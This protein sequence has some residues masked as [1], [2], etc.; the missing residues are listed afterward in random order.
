MP[1]VSKRG[2]GMTQSPIRSLIPFARKAKEDGVHV[3]HLNIGQPD[4]KTPEAA[5]ER[6][7][8]YDLPIIEYGASEGEIELREV[9]REYY[10]KNVA[11]VEL[12][13]IYVTTGASEAILFTLFSCFES[14]EE[15]IIP[16]PFYANYIGFSHVSG[17]N[18]VPV[19]STI[20]TGFSLPSAKSFIEKI[21]DKTKA[22]FLCN[23]GNPTGN[24]YSREE[25]VEI[26]QLVKKYDLFLIVDEVY[27]EFCYEEEFTS[28]LS[29]DNLDAHVVVIDSIS[30]VFSSCGSRIGFIVSRN[31]ELMDNILKYAQLRL[32]PPMIGQQMATACFQDRSDYLMTVKAEYNRRRTYLY[33]RL[34]QMDGVICYLPKAAFYNMTELPV[35]DAK[36]FCIWLLKEFRL[37]GE[38]IMMA[39]GNGFYMNEEKGLSQV[40]IAFVLGIPEL[41][42]AMDIL[43]AALKEYTKIPANRKQLSYSYI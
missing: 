16:E 36:Q 23:P 24:L 30:K 34:S 2:D 20:E 38:T 13:N 37:N 14:D 21:T 41:T 43:E 4:I 28:I 17:V 12:K 22:I 7:R 15:I 8:S 3:Y 26:A 1:K 29:I 19:D 40:R 39:P 6:L 11:Q 31:Q 42:K 27:R 35:K 33:E 18:L 32:C 5:I 10:C 25:L 9:V